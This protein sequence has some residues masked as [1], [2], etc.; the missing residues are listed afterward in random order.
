[1]EDS[2]DVHEL[3]DN[4]AIDAAS[5]V[6]LWALAGFGQTAGF[7]SACVFSA[8]VSYL[9]IRRRRDRQDV[10]DGA[11]REPVRPQ[12]VPVGRRVPLR[13]VGDTHA[14]RFEG[15]RKWQVHDHALRRGQGFRMHRWIRH[16]S[17]VL[18]YWN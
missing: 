2:E 14:R 8:G 1:M 6:F 5:T 18:D 17:P 12:R 11:G 7:D 15:T 4:E 3:Y 9:Y 10:P 16:G 13:A